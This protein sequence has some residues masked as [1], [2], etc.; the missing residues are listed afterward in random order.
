MECGLVSRTV[1]YR[2]SQG[3]GLLLD[4]NTTS[5]KCGVPLVPGE[6]IA[7]M[8]TTI[9]KGSTQDGLCGI[10]ASRFKFDRFP[11]PALSAF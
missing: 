6:E 7:R 8:I 10:S 11:L 5:L 3:L 1:R 2:N 9:R 4:D